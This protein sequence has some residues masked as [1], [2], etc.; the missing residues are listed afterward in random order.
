[1]SERMAWK[2]IKEKYPDQWVGLTEVRYKPDNDATIESAVVL[3][4]DKSKTELTGMQIHTNGRILAVYT[5]PDNVFQFGTVG[6]FG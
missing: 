2:E 5:T 3:Y 1:M 4:T 6:F